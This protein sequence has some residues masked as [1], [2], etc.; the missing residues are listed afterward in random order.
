MK[1]WIICGVLGIPIMWVLQRA[2]SSPQQVRTVSCGVM[3]HINAA[4]GHYTNGLGNLLIDSSSKGMVYIPGGTFL[5]GSNESGKY[6]DEAPQH[7]V[8]LKS[9]WMDATEVTNAQFAAFI[10]ATGYVT[11]AEKA[12][13]WNELKKALP[14]GTLKPSDDQLVAASLVFQQT[15]SPVDFNNYGQWWKWVEG[16]NWKHPEGMKSDIIGKENYPVVHVS[17]YDAMAYCKWAGKRLPTEAEWEYAARGSQI[18]AKYPWG[19]EAVT[20][21]ESKMNS[22]EGAFPYSN[23]KKDGYVKLAPVKQYPSNKYGLFDMAGNVW[24]WCS[25][26]YDAGYYKTFSADTVTNPQGPKKSDDP[27][28]PY[29]PKKSLRGGSF[30]CNDSY[31]SG[32][33]VAR[34]MKSSPDTG[35]ENTGFRCV[36]SIHTK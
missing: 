22:W 28:E 34:R 19:Q 4:S 6:G 15:A 1:S 14:P 2:Q 33:R 29:T 18:N 27:Y 9:F 13:D 32:Y 26:W 25:D 31:C 7:W 3:G 35:L 23:N 8:N 36:K 12:P 5:M 10:S 30:L 17:W 21:G 16:A 20:K 24:E 11:T